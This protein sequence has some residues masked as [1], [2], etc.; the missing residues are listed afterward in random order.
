MSGWWVRSEGPN[1]AGGER[2]SSR[3]RDGRGRGARH[4]GEVGSLD[5]PAAARGETERSL[6]CKTK[7]SEPP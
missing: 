3:S 6:V 2:L 1:G 4:E 7:S 5:S